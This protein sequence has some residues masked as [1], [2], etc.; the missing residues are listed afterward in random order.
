MDKVE[1]L[2]K[3]NLGNSVAEYDKN[4]SD[5]FISTNYVEELINNNYDIIKGVKGSG[6]TA[7]LVALSKN[8]PKYEQLQNVI[9]VEAINLK[10]DP[11]FKRAFEE[12]SETVEEQ[13]LI[14]S[15]KIYIINLIWKKVVDTLSGYEKLDKY[16]KECNLITN[17]SGFLAKILYAFHRVVPKFS[18]TFNTDGSVTQSVEL[19]KSDIKDQKCSINK[20]IDFNY[21]FSTIDKILQNNDCNIWVMIDRLDDAFPDQTTKSILSLKSLLYSYKDISVYDNFKVKVFMRDDIYKNI[22]QK[23][24]TSLTH[25][26]SKSLTSI[27]WDKNKLEQLLIERL[28]FNEEFKKYLD[29]KGVNYAELN[30]DCRN[31]ILKVLFREQVDIGEKNPDTMGWIIN[32]ITDGLN[33]FTPRDLISIVDKARQYQID[34]WKLNNKSSEE[35]YLI[36]ASA[37]RLAYAD[38]SKEKLETQLYAEYPNL[39]RF[40]E[41]FKDSKAEHNEESLKLILG[42][43][44]K[45]TTK[46]LVDIGFIEEKQNTWKIPFIYREGLKISQGKAFEKVNR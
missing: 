15:W 40:I 41:K 13:K 32:H 18:N 20:I 2:K 14:D 42:R 30:E 38:I 23:G 33:I 10:G 9:L 34:E 24:F 4:L 31:S 17:E 8:Q 36:G 16:L 29:D 44:W 19:A 11:D 7:I 27:K 43:R 28:L 1:L 46:K 6:K 5:Y 45:W 25:V 39:R 12:I 21:I 37:L 35:T 3:L 22:T 26:A